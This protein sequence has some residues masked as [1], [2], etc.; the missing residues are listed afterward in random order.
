MFFSA[1]PIIFLFTFISFFYSGLSYGSGTDFT[2]ALTTETIENAVEEYQ[3]G[4]WL[5]AEDLLREALEDEPEREDL[6]VLMS[7]VIGKRGFSEYEKGN[8]SEAKLLFLDALYWD[9]NEEFFLNLAVIYI[10]EKD[11]KNTEKYFAKVEKKDRSRYEL[12]KDIYKGLGHEY[13][14][15][16]STTKALELY[17][18]GSGFDSGDKDLMAELS[19]L[20]AS[21]REEKDYIETEG[22]HFTVKY[23]GGENAVIGKVVS[24]ILEEAYLTIGAELGFYPENNVSAVIYSKKKFSSITDTPDWAGGLYDGRI[25]IPVKGLRTRT[26][27]LEGIIYHEYTHA[28]V[29]LLGEGHAPT[30][31]NE[32]LAQYMEGKL[33]KNVKLDLAA[34]YKKNRL[35]LKKL[36]GSFLETKKKNVDVVYGISLSITEFIIRNYGAF[37]VKSII[38]KTAMG[39]TAEE[40]IEEVIGLT[41]KTLERDW[42]GSI[43]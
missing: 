20:R 13:Y 25:N 42:L 3:K 6:M 39:R 32:G 30:W 41:Y 5:E 34:A 14:R 33:S 18:L 9:E 1:R 23:K 2:I 37:V 16:G 11:L 24:M 35:S 40:A 7:F 12:Y 28:L 36:E 8:M 31:L 10:K 19:K 26:K 38:E 27:E 29:Q 21:N 22:S 4:N 17:E 15:R 43:K